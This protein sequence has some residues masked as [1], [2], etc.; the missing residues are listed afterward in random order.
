MNIKCTIPTS[1]LTTIQPT[2]YLINHTGKNCSSNFNATNC[3]LVG[4]FMQ[5][6]NSK[7]KKKKKILEGDGCAKPVV[8]KMGRR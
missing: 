3:K 2:S 1:K 6:N 5:N 7:S 8:V 4:T